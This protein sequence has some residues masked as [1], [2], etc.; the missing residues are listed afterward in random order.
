MRKE[1]KKCE[2]RNRGTRDEREERRNRGM[3]DKRKGECKE[4]I[5][6][7]RRNREM[8]NERKGECEEE[9]WCEREKTEE[10]EMKGKARVTK[11]LPL[12]CVM[13]RVVVG[14]SFSPRGDADE[15]PDEGGNLTLEDGRVPL[16]DVL[17]VHLDLPVL[18]HH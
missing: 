8:R 7:E 5:W 11:G 9:K 10:R 18:L 14:V 13:R 15:V 12:T 1:G 3:R 16:Q 2:R 17:V 6:C 4:D